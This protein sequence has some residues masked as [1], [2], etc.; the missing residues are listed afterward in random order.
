M[1]QIGNEKPRMFRYPEEE[2]IRNR[3]GFNNDGA[4][5]LFSRVKD[6]SKNNKVLGVNLGKNKITSQDKAFEDY[7]KLYNLSNAI[8]LPFISLFYLI[9]KH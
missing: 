3:M 2:S 7:E 8:I 6:C 1:G 5:A 4:D 9:T